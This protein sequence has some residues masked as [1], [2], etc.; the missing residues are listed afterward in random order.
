MIGWQHVVQRVEDRPQVRVD[1]VTQVAGKKAQ[2]FTGLDG[3]P[4]KDN[5]LDASRHQ[6][7]HRCSDREVGLAG[8]G[9]PQ[10]ENEL[11]IAQRLDV[12]CL[13]RRTRCDEPFAGVERCIPPP[14]D[15][16]L[17]GELGRGE[18]NR[19]L[20][21]RQ[22]NL[23]TSLETVVKPRQ[24]ELGRTRRRD[25]ARDREPVPTRNNQ[26]AKLSLDP[27]KVLI[28]LAV[29]QRKQQV[30]VKFQL[31]TVFDLFDSRHFRG[32]SGHPAR[33]GTREPARLLVLA[34]EISTGTISP[35]PAGAAT[36]T[37]W[38]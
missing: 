28:S 30:I 23:L 10:P 11:I 7:V 13:P 26:D 6:E 19:S 1:L 32:E 8:A 20:N 35:S 12:Y 21:R 9:G 2:S 24:R 17:V 3:R 22:I 27:I 31:R 37:L 36:W 18:P 15:G 34:P 5:P 25:R 16:A 38:R 29:K 14:Q 33:T 4:R